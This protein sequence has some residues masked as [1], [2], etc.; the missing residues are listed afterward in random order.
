VTSVVPPTVV[1]APGGAPLLGHALRLRRNPLVFLEQLRD[2]GDI[3][4]FRLGPRRAYLLNDP[5]LVHQVLVED[6]GHY[7]KG[8]LFEKGRHLL[9]N[10]LAT[11][12][13]A[14]HGRQRRLVQPAFG[15][16]N[17]HGY[18]GVMADRSHAVA[19]GWRHGQVITL[20]REM[21][22]LT[23]TIA[24]RCLFATDIA[25]ADARQVEQHMG[26]VFDG[27]ARR[28]Y[29]PVGLWYRLPTI[30][31]RRFGA[32]LRL[33]HDLVD[34]IVAG[35]QRD[36]VRSDDVLSTLLAARDDATGQGMTDQQ[37]HDEVITILA[38]GTE[39]VAA[40]L[41]W[42]FHLLA[43]HPEVETR[44]HE[45]LATVLRGRLPGHADIA[46]LPYLGAVAQESL[47]LYPPVW[48]L[49]RTPAADV[50]LGGLAVPAGAQVFFSPY[51]LHRDPRWFPEP[52]R[53]DPDR[54]LTGDARATSRGA[55]LPFGLGRRNCVGGS[56]AIAELVIVLATVAARW[57][58]RP[59][60]G[61]TPTV[62]ALTTLRLDGLVMT[63][64]E[65]T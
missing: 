49:P 31:N 25:H 57:T 17:V 39:T 59:V 20:D 2:L 41:T 42:T 10:G 16:G 30:G 33:L 24:T 47:R 62:A 1:A 56:F 46:A 29:A 14:F 45:E 26:T 63:T 53:F 44:L 61:T 23:S 9:G 64:L 7:T 58:L 65:R 36:G 18:A 54:W 32:A 5:G 37:V 19:N 55:Y 60:P 43:R 35:Y 28:A 4:V 22:R 13:G 11:S 38:G 15:R 3:A 21:A 50:R 6:S 8:I 52:H 34:R 51:A 40:A 12:E 48:L 27:A